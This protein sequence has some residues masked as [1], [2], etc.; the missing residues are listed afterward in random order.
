MSEAGDSTRRGI[1]VPAEIAEAAR[2][3]DD[4][5]ANATAEHAV[6]DVARRRTAAWVYIAATSLT[7]IAA[8]RG[9]SDG[10][11]ALAVVFALIAVY[12]FAAGRPLAVRE[13]HA[14]DVA[15]R[16]TEFPVGHASAT[17]GFRGPLARPVWNILIFSADDPP[18][19]RGLVRVDGY[20]GRVVEQYVEAIEAEE[21]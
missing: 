9:V 16:A 7:I 10:L 19:A 6:P 4:L 20:D 8:G 14:L 21:A 11:W 13:D 12:H 18:S 3:P 5:D 17:L 15:N 1:E 2:M